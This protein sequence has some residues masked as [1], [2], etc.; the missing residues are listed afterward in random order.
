MHASIDP[1]PRSARLRSVLLAVVLLGG[2]AGC[3]QPSTTATAG[4]PS[5]PA[6]SGGIPSDH[7]LIGTWTMDLS[8]ADLTAGGITDP[9][10]L[11]ENAGRYSWTFAADGTWTQ[12]AESLDGAPMVN[13]VFRGTYL[14]EGDTLIAT[15]TFPEQYVDSG[16]HY[17]WAID[18]DE[19]RFDLLDPPDPILPI[20]IETHPWKRVG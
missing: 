11:N 8:R 3:G 15:T 6:G 16:L 13:P 12:V 9:G 1:A 4:A 19:V 2:V 5:G 7:P 17:T 20:M 14:F 10:L 18:G